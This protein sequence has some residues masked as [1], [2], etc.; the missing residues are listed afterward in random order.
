MTTSSGLQAGLIAHLAA[1][2]GV[3]AVLGEPARVRDQAHR[4]DAYPYLEVSRV[5]SR[6]VNAEGC[7]I[8]QVVTLNVVSTLG[9]SEEVRLV[10]DAVR[11]ALDLTSNVMGGLRVVSLRMTFSDVF[12]SRDHRRT[13]GVMRLRAVTEDLEEMTA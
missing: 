11:R 6:A 1:D 13:L 4:G 7:G 3:R 9:G 12:R 2:A 10:I 5:E 8:E